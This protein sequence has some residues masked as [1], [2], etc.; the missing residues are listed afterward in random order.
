M[1]DISQY[2]DYIIVQAGAGGNGSLIALLLSRLIAGLNI[3][4]QYT[5]LDGDTVEKKNLTRQHFAINDIDRNKA[6]VLAERY[7]THFNINI[8]YMDSYIES[9]ESLYPVL[10]HNFGTLPILIGAVDNHKARKILHE[11]YSKLNTACYIDCGCEETYGQAVIG[12]KKLGQEYL[13]PAA[14]YYPEM[15]ED[16]APPQ[17][18]CAEAPV[19]DISANIFSAAAVFFY[20][21]N[22]LAFKAIPA[23]KVTFDAQTMVMR[24]DY[25]QERGVQS[26]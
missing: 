22:I 4:P 7:S 1:I 2:K 13:K 17:V 24:P 8:Q 14:Y 21:N 25:I 26:A 6:E 20:L 10:G 5:I 16:T 12:Y 23:Q 9:V 18:G 15:L 19:Q 3:N 11:A